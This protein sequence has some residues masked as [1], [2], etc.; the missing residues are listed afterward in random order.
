MEQGLTL[1]DPPVGL[2]LSNG[3]GEEDLGELGVVRNRASAFLEIDSVNLAIRA[4][5]NVPGSRVADAESGAHQ[6]VNQDIFSLLVGQGLAVDIADT[7]DHGATLDHGDRVA[8]SQAGLAQPDLHL[9][10]IS[11]VG[12]GQVKLAP[13][14]GLFKGESAVLHAESDGQR[15][16]LAHKESVERE[17]GLSGSVWP[18]EDLIT[19][20]A[21]VLF[22]STGHALGHGTTQ[23]GKVGLVHTHAGA[24][25][26]PTT[27]L[28]GRSLSASDPLDQLV[29]LG[30]VVA[31][32]L[33]VGKPLGKCGP[34]Q[35][36]ALVRS[37]H[38]DP[39]QHLGVPATS[40][41]VLV[42]VLLP[43]LGPLGGN[44]CQHLFDGCGGQLHGDDPVL[45]GQSQLERHEQQEL[46]VLALLLVHL[47]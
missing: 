41:G 39:G 42:E 37:T 2:V 17:R 25:G 34:V 43:G 29:G 3:A 11:D 20:D 15:V 32:K 26:R 16:H 5:E 33:L 23:L 24:L 44:L 35:H 45:P 46:S 8:G 18:L 12:K 9:R 13:P 6:E 40:A 27:L 4:D 28:L 38:L 36:G 7:V 30:R 22:A 10:H 19:L 21:D 1:V 14:L 31:V 47:A